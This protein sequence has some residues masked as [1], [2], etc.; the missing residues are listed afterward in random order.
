MLMPET[1][2]DGAR[3]I[4]EELCRR[5]EAQQ[6]PHAGSGVSCWV[7]ISAG[8]AALIPEQDQAASALLDDADRMLYLAK[9]S[10]RN[11]VRGYL[12]A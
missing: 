12:S 9:D 10:G 5:I 2:A 11:C 7:T 6:I 3:R 1:D 8:Y 4:A